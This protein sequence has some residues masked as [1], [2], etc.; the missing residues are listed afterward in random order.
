MADQEHTLFERMTQFETEVA[1]IPE[2]SEAGDDTASVYVE[3]FDTALQNAVSDMATV[4]SNGVE[5]SSSKAADNGDMS[6][7]FERQEFLPVD[8]SDDFV[9]LSTQVL[10][11]AVAQAADHHRSGNSV[12]ADVIEDELI[13]NGSRVLAGRIAVAWAIG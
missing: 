3:Q 12:R 11:R 10:R 2:S 6:F 5:A 4:Y 8:A 1:A 7:V 13:Q 9:A